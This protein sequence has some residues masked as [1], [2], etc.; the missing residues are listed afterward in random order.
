M[1]H[2]TPPDTERRRRRRPVSLLRAIWEAVKTTFSEWFADNA[3][4]HGA[5]IAFYSIFSLSPLLIIVISVAGLVF[6]REAVRGEIVDQFGGLIG[7]EGAREIEQ[8]IENADQPETG[9]IATIVGLVTLFLGATAVFTQL[10]TALNTIWDVQQRSDRFLFTMLLDRVLSFAMVQCIA[11]LLLVSLVV[12]TGMTALANYLAGRIP[13]LSVLLVVTNFLV[14]LAVITLLFAAIFRILPDVRIAWGD[15]WIGALATA[16]LFV[17]GKTL[18]GLYIG[19]TGVASVYGAAGSLI[20][21][22]LWVYY[23]AQIFLLGA[24]FT[25]V[26]ARRWGSK[27]TAIRHAQILERRST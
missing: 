12:S 9:T 3:P 25:Q 5:A 1:D 23:S 4:M 6:G 2:G 8:I 15:V 10:K 22:L 16:L 27:M 18:I 21:L 7:R 17:A 14:S 19:S 20:V 24:E 11:F 26:Y 13:A